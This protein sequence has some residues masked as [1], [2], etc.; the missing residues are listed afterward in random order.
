MLYGDGRL[1][2]HVER[3]SRMISI[4]CDVFCIGPSRVTKIQSLSRS[5]IQDWWRLFQK[6]CMSRK[7][8]MTEGWRP[9]N[10]APN[11]AEL[12][13]MVGALFVPEAGPR[14]MSISTSRAFGP[15]RRPEKYSATTDMRATR[16]HDF[17]FQTVN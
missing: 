14:R 10:F 17:S 11:A 1:V 9:Y 13:A 3:I 6:S 8:D 16:G 7:S 5:V 4:Y 2:F 12:R 15:T